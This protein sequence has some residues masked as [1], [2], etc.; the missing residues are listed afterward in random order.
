M[1]KRIAIIESGF[2]DNYLETF[3]NLC[4]KNSIEIDILSHKEN[5]KYKNLCENFYLLKTKF[6]PKKLETKKKIEQEI[7]GTININ[8]YDYIFSDCLPLSFTCNVFHNVSI[9]YKLNLSPNI[10]YYTIFLLTHL[11]QIIHTRYYFRN[12]CKLVTVSKAVQ[13]DYITNGKVAAEKIIVAYPGTNN[14]YSETSIKKENECFTIGSST[15]GFTTKGGYNILEALRVFRK[16]YPHRKIRVKLINPNF[17]N[18]I[19]LKLY[20]FLTKLDKHV[21]FLG[22]QKDMNAFYS[23]LDCLICASRYEAFGRQVTEAMTMNV[24]VIATSNVGAAEIIKDGINGFIAK[25]DKKNLYNNIAD[26]IEEVI[27]KKAELEEITQNA[28]ETALNLT[29]DNF[30]KTIYENLYPTT[31]GF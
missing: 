18:Q 17:S 1:K 8:D 10:I 15:C 2:M 27:S 28:K 4:Q 30:A 5:S 22:F 6:K 23:S 26:K 16:K 3:C 19:L 14:N 7:K 25:A 20:M 31:D 9:I 21:E 11:K 12:C 13:N 24:P 29:W